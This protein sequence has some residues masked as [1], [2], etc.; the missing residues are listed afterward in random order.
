M[1]HFYN[2]PTH[3]NH[4]VP[5]DSSICSPTSPCI[6]TLMYF[7]QDWLHI[8]GPTTS[9]RVNWYSKE[10]VTHHAIHTKTQAEIWL[11][12][13]SSMYLFRSIIRPCHESECCL[14]KYP[15]NVQMYYSDAFSSWILL[16]L[17]ST[18]MNQERNASQTVRAA[19]KAIQSAVF[20]YKSLLLNTKNCTIKTTL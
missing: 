8:L 4:C 6:Y 12:G 16:L 20:F 14:L 11:H 15:L 7:F 5:M 18:H 17:F 13:N 19:C 1:P 2:A 10:Q 9:Q 3:K